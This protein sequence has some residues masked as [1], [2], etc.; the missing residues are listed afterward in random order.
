MFLLWT[1]GRLCFL[2]TLQS[3]DSAVAVHEYS[4][5]FFFNSFFPRFYQKKR[6]YSHVFLIFHIKI[7]VGFTDK[8]LFER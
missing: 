2:M 8:T 6:V 7:L 1:G 4:P 5:H 3:Y